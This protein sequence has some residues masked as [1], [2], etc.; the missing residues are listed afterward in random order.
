MRSG[1]QLRSRSLEAQMPFCARTGRESVS[2]QPRFAFFL[3]VAL[4]SKLA[5]RKSSFPTSPIKSTGKRIQKAFQLLEGVLPS[6]L[7]D[8]MKKQAHL[9]NKKARGKRYD[10]NFKAW[11]H[12]LYHVSRKAYRL[13]Q[14]LFNLPS[15]RTLTSIVSKF[16]SNTGF[17]EK[18]LFVLKQRIE[19]LPPSGKFCA[20]LMDEISLKSHLYYDA[21]KDSLVGLED[22]GGEATSG[23]VA[24]SA[25]VLMVRGILLNWKQAVAYYLF[26]ES[27]KSGQ[28]MSIIKEALLLQS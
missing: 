28:L 27:C 14:K 18:S 4:S 22:Y 25:L 16:A 1:H 23:L 24:T 7:L 11:A 26:K 8:F 13:L 6:N 5:G 20:L 12:S 10:N 19:A 2:G 9:S 3:Y 17:N 21:A 15:K